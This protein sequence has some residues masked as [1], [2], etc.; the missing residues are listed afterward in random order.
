[1]LFCVVNLH[2]AIHHFPT[3][4]FWGKVAQQN[5]QIDRCTENLNVTKRRYGEQIFL[6][7]LWPFIKSRFRCN[8]QIHK[9]SGKGQNTVLS[10]PSEGSCKDQMTN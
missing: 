5:W 4:A 8:I 7:V 3:V 2:A 1:M 6:S 10:C 9:L